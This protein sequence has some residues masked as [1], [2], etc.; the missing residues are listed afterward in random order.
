VAI[1][2]AL[3]AVIGVWQSAREDLRGTWQVLLHRP[4]SRETLIGLKLLAGLTTYAA[5]TCL[6]TL[7]FACWAATPGTHAS[8]FVWSMTAGAWEL[9]FAVG[10]LY[11]AGFLCGLRP[12]RWLGTRLL[13]LAACACA[14]TLIEVLPGMG[15]AVRVAFIAVLDAALVSSILFVAQTRDY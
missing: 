12:G 7:V 5:C 4:L 8:P 6:P 11:P 14:V 2:A 3:A 9:L 15:W 10:A 1:A 13:P